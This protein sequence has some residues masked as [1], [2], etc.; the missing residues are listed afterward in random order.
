MTPYWGASFF[1]AFFFLCKRLF[2]FM[3]GEIS[4][5]D[6]YQDEI[7]C[8]ALI[9]VGISSLISGTFLVLKRSAMMVNSLSHTILFGLI[10]T[11]I[12]FVPKETIK[13]DLSLMTIGAIVTSFVTL[14]S[15]YF[16]IHILKVQEEGA[17]GFVFTLFFAL[18]IL[19]ATLYTKNS[20]FGVEAVMGN[21][22]GIGK[23]DLSIL[24]WIGSLNLIILFFWYRGL[25]LFSFD[26][27]FASSIQKSNLSI[28][29]LLILQV[30]MTV[31]GGFQVVGVVLILSYF[32]LPTLIAKSILP[33]LNGIFFLGFFVVLFVGLFSVSFTRHVLSFYHLPISSSAVASLTLFFLFLLCK[34]EA[35]YPQVE[36]V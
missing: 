24:F 6:L 26:P 36:K 34:K 35:Y 25:K 17:I 16:F 30:T 12:L 11:L 3:I 23:E 2:F 31:I 27:A 9:L 18:G 5:D 14:L 19:F 32:V 20:H 10:I 8:L 21:I 22:D 13:V 4:I 29:L 28:L 1:S 15:T 33:R 7:E